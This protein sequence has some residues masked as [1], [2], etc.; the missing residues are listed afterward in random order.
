MSAP[1]AGNFQRLLDAVSSPTLRAIAQH[2]HDAR[3][4]KPMPTWT[5]LSSSVLSPHFKWLWGFQ[6]DPRS[7][8]FTGRLAGAN[9]RDWL[10][11]NFWGASLKDIHPPNVFKES[12]QLL[13]GIISRP[14]A[15]R[16]NGR[17][18]ISAG[19]TVTGERIALPL[20]T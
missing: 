15:A 20:A 8:D 3:G 12:H 2:W 19:E 7:D 17:L 9:I 6:H 1:S 5:D 14:A 11:A 4:Q 10:G 16:M 18:F 13:S